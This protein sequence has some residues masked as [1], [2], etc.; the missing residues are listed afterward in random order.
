MTESLPDAA[1]ASARL[2]LSVR[3]GLVFGLALLLLLPVHWVRGLI[4]ERLDMRRAAEQEVAQGF[5]APVLLHPPVLWFDAVL[6]TG[7][8][9]SRALRAAVVP[10]TLTGAVQLR[11]AWRH[12]GI[13]DVPVFQATLALQGRFPRAAVTQWLSQFPDVPLPAQLRLGLADVQGL[14]EIRSLRFDG[15]AL[16]PEPL[17]AMKDSGLRWVGADV[18]LD[19]DLDF[20]VE[21]ELSGTGGFALLPVARQIELSMAGDW[22]APSF[23]AGM[24]PLEQ[25]IE[26]QGFS[27]RFTSNAF[28]FGRPPLLGADDLVVLGRGDQAMRIDL[29]ED[30]SA[31][32]RNERVGKYALLFIGLTVIGLFAAELLLG[33]R[34]HP[35]HYLLVGAALAL[36]YLQLLALSEQLR[37]GWAYLSAAGSVCVLLGGYCAV[38]LGARRR[39]LAVAAL[40]ALVYGFLYVLIASE[41]LSLLLGASGLTLL[42][43]L[44]MYGTRRIDW[45]AVDGIGAITATTRAS[46]ERGMSA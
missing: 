44:A 23:V 37:F 17:L 3:L 31:Y 29:H 41:E 22:S 28:Q 30:A 34:M 21:L 20:A 26:A 35:L 7:D 9:G 25:R 6:D 38:V 14:R 15:Q 2:P 32:Q 16:Q 40:L 10:E 11:T 5:G 4:A 12:V 39:G 46:T 8:G 24:S 33:L 18:V 19:G 43:A 42:L 1:T 27:A 13:Y 45:Y 36:F